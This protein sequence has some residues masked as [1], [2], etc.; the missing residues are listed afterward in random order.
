MHIWDPRQ[1]Y[2]W[3]IVL[4][5][6]LRPVGLLFHLKLDKQYTSKSLDKIW[7]TLQ[8]N[9]NFDKQNMSVVFL[10]GTVNRILW[11]YR[12]IAICFG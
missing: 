1:F 2:V 9:L 6:L 4:G 8:Y 3:G 11:V 7:N 10:G 12:D 5:W